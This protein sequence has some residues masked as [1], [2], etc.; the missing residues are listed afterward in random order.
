MPHERSRSTI[1]FG[2]FGTESWQIG[3]SSTCLFVGGLHEGQGGLGWFSASWAQG[4]LFGLGL[5]ALPWASGSA[6]QLA[7]ISTLGAI[8]SYRGLCLGPGPSAS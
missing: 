8:A 1:G 2:F 7:L 3:T 4:F 5:G 6:V